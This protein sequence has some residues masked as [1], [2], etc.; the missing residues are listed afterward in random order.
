MVTID[1]IPILWHIMKIFS[2]H[3]VNEFVICLGYKGY[4]IKEYFANYFLHNSNV[5]FDLK[6][7]KMQ[8]HEN[9]AEPWKVTLID[10]G[11]DSQTGGRLLRVKK[12]LDGDEA[13]CFTYG[14]GVGDVDISAL[15]IF[16]KAHGKLATVT[17]VRPPGRFGTISLDGDTVSEFREKRVGPGS[18]INGGFFILSNKIFDYIENDATIWEDKPLRT[19]SSEGNLVAFAMKATGNRWIPSGK[20]N[21]SKS[22]GNPAKRRG[23]YGNSRLLVREKC[24]GHRTYRFQR[25]L[26][27][28]LAQPDECRRRWVCPG[29]DDTQLH[30]RNHHA[31]GSG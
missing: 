21:F 10:T 13:F 31:C 23:R 30:V 19:L 20:D 29:S 18:Y 2:A 17:A 24:P 14:D 6:A 11:E 5:T 22:T 9:E 3:G 16:H 25:N 27:V 12:Y 1:G 7:N 26:A 28:S 15:V 8:V 4:I